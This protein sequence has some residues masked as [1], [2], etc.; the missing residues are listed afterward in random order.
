MARWALVAA[1][2]R[3]MIASGPMFSGA[4]A[5]GS[6]LVLTFDDVGKGLR[7]R[8]G[9]ALEEFALAGADHQW[10]WASAKIKRRNQVIVWSDAV[11]Q[12][13]AVRYAFNSNPRH[14]N[15]TNDTDLPA[16]PFRSDNWPGP[17]D[18]KR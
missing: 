2:H 15:L 7:V 8:D 14:P 18:G 13:Q 6:K 5:K 17:T 9:D 11:P 4:K 12:P 1:Y 16:A 10:H 3:K